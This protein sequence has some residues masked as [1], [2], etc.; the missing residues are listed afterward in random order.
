MLRGTC[1]RKWFV[2]MIFGKVLR[3]QVAK[4][5]SG[6]RLPK[7]ARQRQ[8]GRPTQMQSLQFTA[9]VKELEKQFLENY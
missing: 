2:S 8:D 9:Y 1:I 4:D 3:Y 5:C 7:V 6:F